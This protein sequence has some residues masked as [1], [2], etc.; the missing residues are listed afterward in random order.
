M[1]EEERKMVAIGAQLEGLSVSTKNI[2]KKIVVSEMELIILCSFAKL[3][4][5]SDMSEHEDEVG[6]ACK[7]EKDNLIKAI[8]EAF[9]DEEVDGMNRLS[10]G[11]V[12]I[13]TSERYEKYV[14]V[15]E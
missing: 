7:D 11:L 15:T 12:A 14:L 1:D 9:S 4:F 3:G 10:Q 2:G 5:L 8:R 6:L 13:L